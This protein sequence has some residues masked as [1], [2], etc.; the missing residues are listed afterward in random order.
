MLVMLSDL[1]EHSGPT[2]IVIDALDECPE[3]ARHKGLSCFLEHL[4]GLGADNMNLRLFVTSRAEVDIRDILLPFVHHQLSL[5]DAHQHLED[6]SQ[7]IVTE[8]SRKEYRWSSDVKK[9]VCDVLT[10][11]SRGMYVVQ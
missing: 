1:L 4:C 5:H 7:H 6:L 11:K 10:E 2:C 3:P 9:Y 8:L